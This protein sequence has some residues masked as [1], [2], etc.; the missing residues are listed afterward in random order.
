[1]APDP[2]EI[3]LDS[4]AWP[5]RSKGRPADMDAEIQRLRNKLK[6]RVTPQP[7]KLSKSRPKKKARKPFSTFEVTPDFEQRAAELDAADSSLAW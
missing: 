3:H 4:G 6:R 2:K 5:P 7:A 1:M